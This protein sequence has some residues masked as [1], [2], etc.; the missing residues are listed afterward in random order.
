MKYYYNRISVPEHINIMIQRYKKACAKYIGKF[1]SD[2]STGHISFH[3]LP[4][5]S[6]LNVPK[7]DNV[8]LYYDKVEGCLSNVPIRSLQ[9]IGFRYLK[10][11]DKSRTIIAELNLDPD[12]LKW[13]NMIMDILSPGKTIGLPHI[14]IARN[15]SI[16]QFNILWP[17]FEK[18]SYTDSFVV[19]CINVLQQDIGKGYNPML[20]FKN[21]PLSSSAI[22]S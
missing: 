19:D 7:I 15:I 17:H 10:H 8:D 3:N 21:M 11:G 22:N 6:L 4:L 1:P 5:T 18:F 2:K 16:E 12:I 20:P 14:T 13:F 9:I